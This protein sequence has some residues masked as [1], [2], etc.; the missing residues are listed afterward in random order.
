[1]AISKKKTCEYG[2][3]FYKNSDCPSCPKCEQENKPANGFLSRLAA[4]A[5]RALQNAGIDT[6]KKLSRKTEKEVLDLHGIG[7]TTIP[8]L[9]EALSKEGLS[10]K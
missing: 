10:F 8:T 9:Q 1:M 5:R 2:H 3:V 4:P 7:K 6:L